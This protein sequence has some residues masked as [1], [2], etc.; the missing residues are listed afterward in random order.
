MSG[1]A[2][3]S[4]CNRT[5]I[6]GALTLLFAATALP[7]Y[8]QEEGVFLDPQTGDYLVR[9]IDNGQLQEETF[10]PSTKIDPSVRST[11]GIDER[12]SVTYRYLVRNA[13]T[14][15]QDLRGIDIYAR[16]AYVALSPPLN[17]WRSMVARDP[18]AGGYFV[19]W[20]YL[21]SS[22]AEE[23]VSTRG[24]SPGTEAALFRVRSSALPGLG[25][26]RFQGSAEIT[27]FSDEGPDPESPVGKQ[28]HVLQKNDFVPRVAAV[29]K[30]PVP[31]PFDAAAVLSSLQ[32]HV[33][34]DIVEMKLIDPVFA[35]QLDR[36]LQAAIDA[37]KRG[38]E[39]ALRGELKALR[40]ELK[41]AHPDLENEDADADWGDG[42]K[43]T[44]RP[45]AKLA[46]KVLDFD[47]KYVLKRVGEKD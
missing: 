11:F 30:I 31:T 42:S 19:G 18:T 12:E 25:V 26:M 14:S 33:K 2:C 17:H 23:G 24:L 4:F 22:A 15:R 9:F 13:K 1:K 5:A 39:V 46:A 41:R 44:K 47:I 34:G 38:N 3:R 27:M 10:Y 16:H 35:T 28:L 37:A 7:V 40:Q 20:V 32:T 21:A 29:P 36:G 6:A 43:T 45:I 8:S